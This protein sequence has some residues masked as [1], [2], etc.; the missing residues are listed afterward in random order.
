MVL[1][2]QKLNSLSALQFQLS[3][4]TLTNDN[5]V[6]VNS[7]NSIIMLSPNI[8]MH[9]IKINNKSN[10]TYMAYIGL[11]PKSFHTIKVLSTTWTSTFLRHN[12]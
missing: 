4:F 5:H 1:L 8:I 10:N 7:S 11:E 2:A 3:W 12:K 6:C 9:I